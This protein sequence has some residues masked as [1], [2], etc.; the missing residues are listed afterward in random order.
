[1]LGADI[2]KTASGWLTALLSLA[3]LL[4]ASPAPAETILRQG[5]PRVSFVSFQMQTEASQGD[6]FTGSAFF[7]L[8]APVD[9]SEK[10]FLHFVPAGQ[11]EVR[12]NADFFPRFPTNRWE[13]GQV[14]EVGPFGMSIPYDLEP[15]D[16]EV[17]MGLMEISADE[18]GV[19][20]VREPLTNTEIK[21]FALGKI[22][23]KAAE[24]KEGAA[25]APTEFDL[26]T[27]ASEQD[28][29]F[30]EPRG[31]TISLF[32]EG[33]TPMALVTIKPEG[34]YPA[35]ALENYFSLRP[36][37]ADWSLYDNLEIALQGIPGGEGGRVI[38]QINDKSGRLFKK[39]I[40]FNPGETVREVVPMMDTGGAI[41]ISAISSVKLF[42]PRPGKDFSFYLSMLR[43]RSRGGPSGEP[44]LTF[45]RLD[46]PTRVKRGDVFKLSVVYKLTA[47]LFPTH[48]MFVHVYREFDRAGRID[49]DVPLYPPIR[50]W[51]LNQEIAV[52]SGPLMLSPDSPPGNYVVRAGLY[53][54]ADTGGGG[55]N[56]VKMA[57]WDV[58]NKK[59]T[60][61]IQ[62]NYPQDFIKEPYTNPEIQDWE[63]GKLTVE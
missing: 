25:A 47:P 48:K 14:V 30:W 6:F 32:K 62:P 57:D 56:Y 10:I 63:V 42:L 38:L 19:R 26:V 55:L 15:G 45:V 1:M 8:T 59:V 9:K 49:V 41:N 46:G 43:L 2:M 52:E 54:I 35:I 13:V 58:E 27:F 40:R 61:I 4:L 37:T 29:I 24:K 3:A 28:L 44:S 20:F 39:E 33:D 5:S 12:V 23:V 18:K 21:N 51:A 31:A 50:N 17:R 60:N 36:R 16:Y 7:Q 11:N 34:E 22:S 53:I